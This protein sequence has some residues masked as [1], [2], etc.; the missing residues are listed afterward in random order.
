[1]KQAA[2]TPWRWSRE[3]YERMVDLGAFDRVPV[4][5]VAG[6]LIVAEPQ[7]SYHA[8]GVGIVDD[9]FRAALPPGFLVRV[10]A[11]VAL[12]DESE[13]E[14]DVAVVPGARGDYR[15][16]HPIRP[17]LVVE[18]SDSSLEFDRRGKASLYARGGVQDYWIVNLVDRMLEVYR[19]PVPDPAALHGWRY[20]SMEVF[21]PS[22]TVAPLALPS[23]RLS[24]SS[25]LP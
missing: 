22:V 24:V 8:T 14:P 6:Q 21:G 4:E 23:V 20:A 19:E 10:Q 5:L 13:P 17:A 12:D 2:F 7:G 11:P 15:H 3:A 1:M 9:A 25:L 18:V 16:A